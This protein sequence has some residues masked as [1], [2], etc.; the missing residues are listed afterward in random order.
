MSRYPEYDAWLDAQTPKER[1]TYY[2]GRAAILITLCVGVILLAALAYFGINNNFPRW[3]AES[4]AA[5]MAGLFL[6]GRVINW[7]LDRTLPP[8]RAE[9]CHP[10]EANTGQNSN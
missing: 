4:M 7:H 5:V 8:P 9:K 1:R 2:V 6:I 3:V 10:A